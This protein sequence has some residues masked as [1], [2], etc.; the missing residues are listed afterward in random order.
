MLNNHWPPAGP[1]SYPVHDKAWRFG[2][3]NPALQPGAHPLS[4]LFASGEDGYLLDG[5][6]SS[7]TTD[8]AGTI[9]C[10]TSGSDPVGYVEDLSGN[11][12]HA[13]Q[14]TSNNKPVYYEHGSIKTFQGGYSSLQRRWLEAPTA[15]R[16]PTAFS[17]F[18][19][20]KMPA[21]LVNIH[22][23][24]MLYGVA[25]YFQL[26]TTQAATVVGEMY[27]NAQTSTIDTGVGTDRGYSFGF[28]RT[29]ALGGNSRFAAATSDA[30]TAPGG[31]YSSALSIGG[32]GNHELA[33]WS[34]ADYLTN[35][36][37]F[38]LFIN[39]QLTAG[40]ITTVVNYM[41]TNFGGL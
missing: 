14:A 16:I 23:L 5:I 36:M 12:N 10:T 4:S 25:P 34:G 30:L 26:Y 32:A 21:S 41:N 29:D 2:S 39:R 27:A 3:R 11:G 40:E 1:L 19:V 35:D 15:E 7:F 37:A 13:V 31:T 38:V 17:L 22:N 6:Y 9:L 20:S 28:T 24:V 33:G 18:V 8:S